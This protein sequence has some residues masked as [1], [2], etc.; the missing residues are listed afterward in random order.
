MAWNLSKVTQK[1]VAEIEEWINNYPRRILNWKTAN[2]LF[3]FF[4]DRL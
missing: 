2:M 1:Q 3:R 4:M